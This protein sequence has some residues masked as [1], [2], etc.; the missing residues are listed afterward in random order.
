MSKPESL[1]VA[2]EQRGR[3][4]A[5]SEDNTTDMVSRLHRVG[6]LVRIVLKDADVTFLD[7]RDR[8]DLLQLIENDIDCVSDTLCIEDERSV[9]IADAAGAVT[10]PL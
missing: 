1:Q 3:E 4:T 6:M 5:L 10:A 2:D 9:L 7:S 8:H